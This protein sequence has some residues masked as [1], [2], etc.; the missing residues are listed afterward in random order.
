MPPIEGKLPRLLVFI[1][2][3]GSTQ[4][5]RGNNR[6]TNNEP[7]KQ[8]TAGFVSL[9]IYSVIWTLVVSRKDENMLHLFN[10]AGHYFSTKILFF[11][12]SRTHIF[13]NFLKSVWSILFYS[14]LQYNST[15]LVQI[16]CPKVC[17]TPAGFL[18]CCF[19][20]ACISKDDMVTSLYCKVLFMS[21]II[22]CKSFILC[23]FI[24]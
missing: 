14:K 19:T 11:V 8:K 13:S 7:D 10:L 15:C 6:D 12:R 1:P 2:K 3:D 20:V 23:K 5:G 21:S 24:Q 22:V 18:H 17:S 9:I 16:T 4:W